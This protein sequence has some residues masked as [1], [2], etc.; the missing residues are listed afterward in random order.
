MGFD[1]IFADGQTESGS[2]CRPVSRSFHPIEAFEES[3][4][5]IFRHP[6][7][8]VFKINHH[9]PVPAGYTDNEFSTRISVFQGI[10][11][12]VAEKL[13]QT[14]RICKQGGL[15]SLPKV[16]AA[17]DRLM[18]KFLAKRSQG[19]I[20]YL[21]RIKIFL[22]V[23]QCAQIRECQLI[24]IVNQTMESNGFSMERPDCL[25]VYR[26]YAI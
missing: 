4:Q 14:L 13:V 6:G 10:V 17:P 16:R 26:S 12:E 5:L 7:R 18:G 21:G 20:K 23:G 2:A 11:Q 24:K 15:I 8:G 3:V 1:D 19:I 22:V 9:L 25:R